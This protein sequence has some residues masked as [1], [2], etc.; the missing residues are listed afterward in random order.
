MV[1]ISL[2]GC[3]RLDIVLEPKMSK[4]LKSWRLMGYDFCVF[5]EQGL[6][7]QSCWLWHVNA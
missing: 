2:R 6:V 3:S 1:K 5:K 4:D 7:S